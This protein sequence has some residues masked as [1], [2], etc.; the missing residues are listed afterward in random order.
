MLIPYRTERKRKKE[1]GKKK[2][3][4]K[5]STVYIHCIHLKALDSVP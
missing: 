2:K 5:E 3:G 4:K 1:K